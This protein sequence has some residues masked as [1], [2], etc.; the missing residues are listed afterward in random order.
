[1]I[2]YLTNVNL[3]DTVAIKKENETIRKVIGKTITGIDQENKYVFYSAFN[4]WPTGVKT[5]E[6]F[7]M[8]QK[9]K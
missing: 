2:Y 3:K 6:H 1:M 5:V 4:E 8:K 7:D 9:L